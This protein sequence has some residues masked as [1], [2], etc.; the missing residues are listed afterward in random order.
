MGLMRDW[1]I[2]P[3]TIHPNWPPESCDFSKQILGEL[4]CFRSRGCF[5]KRKPLK[6]NSRLGSK[7]RSNTN[8]FFVKL[9]SK[10]PF[11]IINM[12]SLP[13]GGIS[14]GIFP[15]LTRFNSLHKHVAGPM[16]NT[17]RQA[18]YTV[19]KHWEPR[20][21]TCQGKLPPQPAWR[22]K[23]NMLTSQ[24]PWHAGIAHIDAT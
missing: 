13:W 8:R 1:T 5:K 20:T 19:T 16:F 15:Q 14:P 21:L 9:Y 12:G 10:Q 11:W 2:R 22:D 4:S 3:Q 24:P 6:Q 7:M 18:H 23:V 17:L